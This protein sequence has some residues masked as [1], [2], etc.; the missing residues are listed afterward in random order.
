MGKNVIVQRKGDSLKEI[1]IGN[2]PVRL[3]TRTEGLESMIVELPPGEGIPRVYSH[4]GEELRIVLKGRVEVEVEGEKYLLEEGD[5]MWHKSELKHVIK[6]PGKTRAVYF[7]VNL[8][9]SLSW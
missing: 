7:S 1:R 6:N 8:P 4:P 5:V 9:P 2:V 3:L